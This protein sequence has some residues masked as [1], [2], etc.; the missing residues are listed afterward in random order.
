MFGLSIKP[1]NDTF[2]HDK[3]TQYL[4]SSYRVIDTLLWHFARKKLLFLSLIV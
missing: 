3:N 2:L 1:E 4:K